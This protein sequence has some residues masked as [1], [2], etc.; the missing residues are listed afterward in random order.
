MSENIYEGLGPSGPFMAKL[1]SQEAASETG[2]LQSGDRGYWRVWG[3]CA[4]DIRPGDLVLAK[5]WQD[6]ERERGIHHFAEYEVTEIAPWPLREDGRDD[7]R[8]SCRIRFLTSTGTYAS[9]G[10]LQVIELA[11]PGTSNYLS[12]YAR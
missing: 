8:N 7:L 10:M 3:A 4:M 2:K 9:V 12:G 6:D 5:W 1:A 11:R